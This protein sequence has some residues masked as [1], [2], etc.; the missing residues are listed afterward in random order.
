[1][2]ADAD[3]RFGE[4]R[5]K[6]RG[7]LDAGAAN[8]SQSKPAV[9]DARAM[10][11]LLALAELAPYVRE[12][13]ACDS[14]AALVKALRQLGHKVTVAAPRTP[15]FEAS[16]L[17]VARRL[18][19]LT[20][21]DGSEVNVLDG[22]L[23]SGAE[24]VLFDLPGLFDHPSLYGEGGK[25]FADDAGRYAT[26]GRAVAALVLQR[27][28]QG[29]AV[30]VVHAH[31]AVACLVP[32]AL[33]EQRVPVV[34]TIHDIERSAV[35]P[36]SAH[37]LLGFPDL[38]SLELDGGLSGVASA[39]RL[40]S[41]VTTVSS[42]YAEE[43]LNPACSGALAS[44]LSALPEG[45]LGI[46]GGVDYATCNPATD[47]ALESRF[48]AEDPSN[49]GRSKVTAL[50]Q[51]ELELELDRPLLV[52]LGDLAREPGS[53]ALFEALPEILKLDL[54]LVVANTGS[55]AAAIRFQAVAREY[56]GD[57]ACVAAIDE[58]FSRQ[59]LAGA[60]LA[61]VLSAGGPGGNRQLFAQRYGA[62]P[63]AFASGGLVDAIVDADAELE[64]G[65]G[66]LFDV[67]EPEALLG[68]LSRAFSAYGNPAFARLRRRVM[69]LDLAWDRPA[70]RYVQV[71]RKLL[72]P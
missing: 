56:P 71:Y 32:L 57:L 2:C 46:P 39:V 36:H 10:D 33:R 64:T 50:K 31:D 1:M 43:L 47:T 5:P 13:E 29:K 30:E 53:D 44:L 52:F 63:I 9:V 70:R 3:N 14:A 45:L 35:F 25:G 19:P 34:F 27:A 59:L 62:V 40:A 18:T 23:P 61:L 4:I 24:L 54:A 16:G 26:F 60:D 55:S 20:L 6:R 11:I 22:Q 58:R 65:T 17:L 7:R 41:T 28:E 8:D 67:L 66:F 68:A 37:T 12:T 49:K 42:R 48:D 38:S 21:S 69:R 51:L 72:S 15:G